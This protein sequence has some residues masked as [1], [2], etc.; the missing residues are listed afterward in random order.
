MEFQSFAAPP[1]FV[2]EGVSTS[3]NGT[4]QFLSKEWH[5]VPEVFS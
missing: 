1:L 3:E 5:T 4:L 2:E